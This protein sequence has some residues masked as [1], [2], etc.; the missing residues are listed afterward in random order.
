LLCI[1]LRTGTLSTLLCLFALRSSLAKCLSTSLSTFFDELLI[2]LNH[3]DFL[4][5]LHTSHFSVMYLT[6][7]FSQSVVCSHI[8]G[9]TKFSLLMEPNL[10]I[11]HYIIVLLVSYLKT[12]AKPKIL[13]IFSSVIF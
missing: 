7:I 6:D 3:E 2:L 10:R 11:F 1:F 12:F 9:S 4:N 5:I 13:K 8:L